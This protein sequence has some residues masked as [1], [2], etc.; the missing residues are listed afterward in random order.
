LCGLS[1]LASPGQA[2]RPFRRINQDDR[3]TALGLLGGPRLLAIKWEG[4]MKA[5]IIVAAALMFGMHSGNAQSLTELAQFAESICGDI[6]R[7][8]L[9]K[10]NIKG[11]IEA[12]LGVIAKLI[13]GNAEIEASKA[14]EIYNGIPL[15]KLP[16]KIP[17][18]SMCKLELIKLLK[19]TTQ[20][21]YLESEKRRSDLRTVGL[22]ID[23]H[24]DG[25]W[26]NPGRPWALYDP[27]SMPAVADATDNLYIDDKLI[28]TS[29][30]SYTS[31]RADCPTQ[32]KWPTTAEREDCSANLSDLDEIINFLAADRTW[33]RGLPLG[34]RL[35]YSVPE[36]GKGWGC[37]VTIR[38]LA[39][40]CASCKAK[41]ASD[42]RQTTGLH[43]FVS[44]RTFIQEEFDNFARALSRIISGGSDAQFCKEHA[45]YCQQ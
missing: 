16:D 22:Y 9:T 12:N 43:V 10:N 3:S 38:C 14:R 21:T 2:P 7:G 34:V 31:A 41:G 5:G 40:N 39:G 23:K 15:D 11:K 17:T 44:S 45:S 19:T 35:P 18:V 6:P 27:C 8:E 4:V 42:T 28:R 20:Q 30:I 36:C 26:H 29:L 33:H 13:S 32:R 24:S 1:K 25:D 37:F